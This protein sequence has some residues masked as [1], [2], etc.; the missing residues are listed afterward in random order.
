MNKRYAIAVLALCSIAGVG[1]WVSLS[2]RGTASLPE[3]A[4]K[5]YKAAVITNMEQRELVSQPMSPERTTVHAGPLDEAAQRLAARLARESDDV[6]GWLLLARTYAYLQ[7]PGEARKAMEEARAHGYTG[8]GANAAGGQATAAPSLRGRVQLDPGLNGK[9]RPMDTLFVYAKAINGPGMPLA[10][11]RFH[12][13]D[14]PVRFSLDDSMA[15]TPA[16]K[17][18]KFPRVRVYA[19]ISRTGQAMPSAGDLQGASPELDSADAHP[20]DILIDH[21]L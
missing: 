15:M 6:D 9:V 4:D 13:S 21:V 12:V 14:L 11:Q 5:P 17:L 8:T 20:V 2:G 19:R 10:I 18:S 16:M 7:R 3:V 1:V